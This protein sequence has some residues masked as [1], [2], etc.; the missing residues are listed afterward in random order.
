M[1]HQKH[2]YP[3]ARLVP[4]FAANEDLNPAQTTLAL[5]RCAAATGET[6][7]IVDC[8]DGALMEAAGIIYNKTLG[9]VLLRGAAL[10]DAQYVTSN[11]HFTAMAAGDATLETILGSLAALSLDYDWVFVA[12]K[13]GCT[14]AHIRLAGAADTCLMAYD[15]H[16]D[17]FM[18]AYWMIDAC[19]RRFPG[20][21][22]L[23]ISMG[24]F[25]DAAETAQLL[26]AS[27]AEFLGAPPPYAGHAGTEHFT[28]H[29]LSAIKAE[30][31]VA[32]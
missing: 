15:T 13:A 27:V 10:T 7:L 22:P 25:D 4:I 17:H 29:V 24:S 11:E 5:A 14:P 12:T 20:F 9:D 16:A 2:Y 1:A 6:V 21:D 30:L 8:Q 23:M 32:A 18:R 28:T 31:A 3:I 19:R 26:R